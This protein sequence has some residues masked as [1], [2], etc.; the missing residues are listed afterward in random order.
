LVLAV[1]VSGSSRGAAFPSSHA[2][3]SVAA[4]VA[5][6][7]FQPKVGAVV[8]FVTALLLVGAVYGGFHYGVDMIAGAVV[9]LGV[10]LA[11]VRTA[12]TR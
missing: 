8:A 9:G 1:L 2:A 10:A 3:V 12:A 6:L 4:S 5:A 7:R 11:A